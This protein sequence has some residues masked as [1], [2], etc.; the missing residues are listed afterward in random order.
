MD[1]C[2]G[3]DDG[4]RSESVSDEREMGEVT[5]D[6]RI[7]D[8]RR[9]S[10]A[11]RGSILVEQIHQFFDD[12]PAIKTNFM[13]IFGGK[14]PLSSFYFLEDSRHFWAAPLFLQTNPFKIKAINILNVFCSNLDGRLWS[15]NKCEKCV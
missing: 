5:L 13:L 3:C 12:H 1:C 7:Q 10:I 6:R 4:R 8:L 2:E 9:T 11:K 14:G 15:A